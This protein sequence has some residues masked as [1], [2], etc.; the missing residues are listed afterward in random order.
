MKI[1]GKLS[2]DASSAS[3]IENLRVERFATLGAVPS[4]TSAD[5]GRVVYV[6][7]TGTMYYGDSFTGA[8]MPFATGGNAFSQTEGDA[9]ETS[10]G[11][12]IN[13]DGTFNAAG[14]TNTLALTNPTSFSNAIQQI[15]NYATANDT[16]YE[17]NDV[18]LSN[19]V[20][21]GAKFLYTPGGANWVDHTLVLADVSDVTAT[22]AEVNELAGGTAVQADFIKLHNITASAADVNVL[23]GAFA[24]G[25]TTT[26]ISYL[27]GVT[28]SIQGQLDGKQALDATLTALAGLDTTAGIVVQT[29]TDTFTKRTLTAPAEGLTI[30]NPAGTAGNPTFALANDLAALEGLTSSGY[31][32]R[33]GDGTATTRTINGVAGRTVVT[34]GDGVASN[35]DVDLDTV[36]QG[37]GGAFLKVTLDAY[38][39]VSQN[40]AVVAGDITGLVDTIYVNVAGDTMTGNLNMGTNYVTMN[41]A[42]TLDTQAA[43]K[44]YVDSVAAGLS[45]KNA[46]RAASTGNVADLAAVTVIDGITLVDGDRVLLKNQTTPSANGIYTY[47]L[48]TTTLARSSDMNAAGEFMSATVFVSEGSANADSGWTQTAEVTTVGSDAVVWYQFSGAS[49]YTWGTGLGNTGNTVFVNLGA[50]IAELP[51][52]E[53]GLDLVSNKAIQLTSALT[54]GQLT[55]VLDG[56]AASG[57]EQS[58]AGLK[59]S[60]N[61]VTNAMILN[62]S[63]TF[64]SDSGNSVT[65]LGDTLIIAGTAAQGIHTSAVTGTLTITAD[66]ASAS[67]KGVA[68]FNTASFAVT[69]GDVTIKAAGVSNAQLA[70]ST[71][72]FTGS[73]ASSDTVSLGGTLTFIDG[74]THAAGD[75]VKTSVATDAVTISMREATTGALGVA[76]FD[77]AH[78]SVTAGAVSL[79]A[80]LDD[81][82]NVSNAD[83]AATGDLLTKTAGDWQNV[84][85]VAVVGSTSVADHNDVSVTTPAAGQTLV[86]IAGEW[87]NRK[88][89]HTET[90]ASSSTWNINHALGQKFCNVT[91]ADDTDNVVIPQSIVFSDANNLVVTFNTAIA[92][93]VMVS[94]VAAA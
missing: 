20:P 57:L 72:G 84:T 17:L 38:G 3:L 50:G 80:T 36:T 14:F 90:V 47:T 44:A 34:N 89:F 11:V 76:S 32:V 60:A 19:A 53:V 41:N 58:S 26:E 63:M 15:A 62:E 71:I 39:R 5:S 93:Q 30:S 48:S 45:W 42:P 65:A 28:S 37:S 27:D 9:I 12:G 92:G 40:T 59:I 46:V 83:A 1:N 88:V 2:F 13:A 91:I 4:Y 21:T 78:F 18:S 56:G 49:T 54:G 31:I 70:N 23:T 74:A 86:Y 68:T 77:G 55:F 6:I 61:G 22:A 24:A 29:G 51:S 33:T 35:T 16:L 94:G 79:A 66:D 69:A 64:N 67:Q 85:R 81:L 7:G 10:L 75:L 82:T 52:D 87:V 43:N 25:I 73:D 8:W